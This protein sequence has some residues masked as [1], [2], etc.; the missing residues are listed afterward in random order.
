[1][2]TTTAEVTK[3]IR[4]LITIAESASTTITTEM[5]VASTATATI[6]RLTTMAKAK[7]IKTAMASITTS[8]IIAE[9]QQQ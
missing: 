7:R 6:V 4:T 9:W 5:A 8:T 3:R 2:A 1:M